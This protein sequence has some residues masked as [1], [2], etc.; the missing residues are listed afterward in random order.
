M[1]KDMDLLMDRVDTFTRSDAGA[2]IQVKGIREITGKAL[3]LNSFGLPENMRGYLDYTIGRFLEYWEKRKDLKDDL[4]PAMSPWYGIA[5]HTAFVGGEVDISENTSW[6]HPVVKSWSDMDKLSLS[7]SNPWFRLVI[8]GMSYLREKAKG[9]FLVKLR[10]GESP[11]DIA[12]VLRGNDMF[13]DFFEYPDEIRALFGFTAKAALFMLNRQS[14]IADRVGGGVIT[15]F[16]VWLPGKGTGHLSEDASVMISN[17]HFREF[18]VP[19]TEKV[20]GEFDH[21]FMHTHSVGVHNIPLIARMKNID[22]I[23]I[24][25]DPNAQRAIEVY[26]QLE[27]DLAGKTVVVMATMDEIRENMDFLRGKKT[28]LWYEAG[29]LEE[30]EQAVRLVRQI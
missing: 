1:R 3:P 25:N 2:L 21:V 19:F 8:D 9:R 17:D 14:E 28:I 20:T 18:G 6:H 26:R 15:G 11:M 29:T 5:E 4:F 24:S 27:D 16:D 13:Y 12:N 23:E 10:G 30:A 22:Y 7:E